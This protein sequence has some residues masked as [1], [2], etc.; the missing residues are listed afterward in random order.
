MGGAAGGQEKGG[1][2][3][4]APPLNQRAWRGCPC[5]GRR[6]KER[7]G[8]AGAWLAGGASQALV[9]SMEAVLGAFLQ[10]LSFWF[11]LAFLLIVLPSVFGLSLGIS[12]FYLQVLVKILEVSRRASPEGCA[13][14][15][16]QGVAYLS[17]LPPFPPRASIS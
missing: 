8:D 17:L 12:E 3:E 13:R 2:S 16:A 10:L 11:A 6:A 5:A 7:A 4:E 15:S 1:S 14:R 9:P